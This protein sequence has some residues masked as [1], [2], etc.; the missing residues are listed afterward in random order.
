[1]GE[2]PT[3]ATEAAALP[4][5]LGLQR[6]TEQSRRFLTPPN[7]YGIYFPVMQHVNVGAA[8]G[9]CRGLRSANAEGLS[10]R[11]TFFIYDTD[12]RGSGLEENLLLFSLIF[13]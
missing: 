7:I 3:G 6:V 4:Q 8:R 2:T 5:T 11:N 1:M 12:E 10:D 9:H 13:A